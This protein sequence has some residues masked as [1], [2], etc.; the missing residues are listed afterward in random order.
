VGGASPLK[1]KVLFWFFVFVVTLYFLFTPGFRPGSVK[2]CQPRLFSPGRVVASCEFVFSLKFFNGIFSK[3]IFVFPGKFKANLS[4]I[5][6]LFV[7]WKVQSES[8]SNR[9]LFVHWKVQ[10]E[11]FSNR[12]FAWKAIQCF[13]ILPQTYKFQLDCRGKQYRRNLIFQLSDPFQVLLFC[14]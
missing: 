7:H 13:A 11:S 6:V 5:E 8:F 2:F 3:G 12:I 4:Q 14:G 1:G 10:S 9:I